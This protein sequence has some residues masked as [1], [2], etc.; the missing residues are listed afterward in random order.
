MLV[1][2]ALG[3]S[4]KNVTSAVV[5]SL[6]THFAC[7][8]IL[9]SA[10][11]DLERVIHNAAHMEQVGAHATLSL[12]PEMACITFLVTLLGSTWKIYKLLPDM[13][14][15]VVI[16][17]R[18]RL[19]LVNCCLN[20][21]S[22]LWSKELAETLNVSVDVCPEVLN[23]NE[24]SDPEDASAKGRYF[25]TLGSPGKSTDDLEKTP[26]TGLNSLRYYYKHTDGVS[27][28]YFDKGWKLSPCGV[29]VDEKGNVKPKTKEPYIWPEDNQ[30][31]RNK[32][33]TWTRDSASKD[34]CDVQ[35]VSE[36][37]EAV[38]QVRLLQVLLLPLFV[39]CMTVDANAWA[40]HQATE[41]PDQRLHCFCNEGDCGNWYKALMHFDMCMAEFYVALALR[42]VGVI[43]IE[44]LR[45]N[46]EVDDTV[47]RLH[48]LFNETYCVCAGL[49]VL[50]SCVSEFSGWY[51]RIDPIF[52]PTM[53]GLFAGLLCIGVLLNTWSLFKLSQN[54]QDRLINRFGRPLKE[55]L[56][57]FAMTVL[58]AIL[59]RFGKTSFGG[60]GISVLHQFSLLSVAS[61]FVV[62]SHLLM[63]YYSNPTDP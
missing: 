47:L 18:W 48:T 6:I 45:H 58:M 37:E 42:S 29:D 24:T 4:Q 54:I 53:G 13:P 11:S 31:S 46:G 51:M 56:P 22:N 49:K 17:R 50:A 32:M 44:L 14:V 43:F 15:T 7:L 52:P 20:R 28:I 30:L 19:P 2:D 35:A 41:Y 60:V 34:T 63:D 21:R 57:Y 61:A 62:I 23:V 39:A 5:F 59:M 9:C 40:L 38:L 55:Q 36:D 3:Y 8:W 1:R 33:M 12:V 25:I 27:V 16:F 26:L 10:W